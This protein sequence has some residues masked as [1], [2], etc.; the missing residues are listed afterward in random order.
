MTIPMRSWKDERR[1]YLQAERHLRGTKP[2]DARFNL[3]HRPLRQKQVDGHK[4]IIAIK[5][6]VAQKD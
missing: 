2:F 6:A 3:F 5:E 1:L 4:L